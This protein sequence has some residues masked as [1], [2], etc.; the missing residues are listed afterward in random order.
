M[1]NYYWFFAMFALVLGVVFSGCAMDASGNDSS[2]SSEGYYEIYSRDGDTIDDDFL[3]KEEVSDAG[4]ITLSVKAP[5]GANVRYLMSNTMA[6]SDYPS[7]SN[8]G[9]IMK[10]YDDSAKTISNI[11]NKYVLFA[12]CPGRFSWDE[13]TFGYW[14]VENYSVSTTKLAV[15]FAQSGTSLTISAT[16]GSSVVSTA[17]VRYTIDGTDPTSSSPLSIV[18]SQ[19]ITVSYGLTVKA[20]AFATGTYTDSDVNTYVM[21]NTGS[22]NP[23]PSSG[24]YFYIDTTYAGKSVKITFEDGSGTSGVYTV[25]SDGKIPVVVSGAPKLSVNII[26]DGSW[27]D[28]AGNTGAYSQCQPSDWSGDS[29]K[30]T[31]YANGGF[32]PTG[33]STTWT[34]K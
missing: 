19:T 22:T 32:T 3:G 24:K 4:K 30:F 23:P 14:E 13:A 8:I 29:V 16:S 26:V 20:K 11:S 28:A 27:R 17:V 33:T 10:F 2:L 5:E 18:G 7:A 6:T 9:S 15:T 21:S 12:Y 34:R 25:A 31:S 1:K